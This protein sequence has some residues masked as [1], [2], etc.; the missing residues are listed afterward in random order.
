MFYTWSGM[1]IFYRT[2]VSWGPIYMSQSLSLTERG[3][4]N[5]TDHPLT[6]IQRKSHRFGQGAHPE[7]EKSEQDPAELVLTVKT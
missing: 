6:W 3:L 4:A 1:P 7:G 5:L 2:Q